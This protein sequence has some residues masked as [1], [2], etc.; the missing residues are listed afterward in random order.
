VSALEVPRARAALA[1]LAGWI[2]WAAAALAFR[3]PDRA[4]AALLAAF[5][6]LVR[7]PRARR[8]IADLRAAFLRGGREAAIFRRIATESRPRDVVSIVRGAVIRSLP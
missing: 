1:T 6:P 5:A 8:A 4:V 2:A 7:A 3:L